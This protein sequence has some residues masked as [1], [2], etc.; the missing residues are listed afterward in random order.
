MRK[1]EVPRYLVVTDAWII[2]NANITGTGSDVT[3]KEPFED[4]RVDRIEVARSTRLW[5][6]TIFR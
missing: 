6:N 3:S 1:A 4:R 5:D 2:R